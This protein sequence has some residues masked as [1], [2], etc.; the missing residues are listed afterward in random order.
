MCS[1]ELHGCLGT[2]VGGGVSPILGLE[3][4][5][6]FLISTLLCDGL[7]FSVILIMAEVVAHLAGK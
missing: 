7:C 2:W 3:S 6:V 1:H 5:W 4:R